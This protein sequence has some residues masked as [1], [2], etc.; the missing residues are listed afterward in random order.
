MNDCSMAGAGIA[1]HRQRDCLHSDSLTIGRAET[2]HFQFDRP[3]AE[4][5]KEFP[6]EFSHLS[7]ADSDRI[8]E[9]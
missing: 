3:Y 1:N 4:N 6:G 5:P 9:T 2:L 8:W 7:K